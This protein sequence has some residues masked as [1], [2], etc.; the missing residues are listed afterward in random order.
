MD[1]FTRPSVARVNRNHGQEFKKAS[2]HYFIFI[3][4][5]SASSSRLF[6]RKAAVYEE[7]PTSL[8]REDPQNVDN[9][10]FQRSQFGWFGAPKSSPARRGIVIKQS[11]R[12]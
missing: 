10:N 2:F 1:Y 6:G 7:L 4:T 5:S 8:L 9:G 3:L 11:R 12:R